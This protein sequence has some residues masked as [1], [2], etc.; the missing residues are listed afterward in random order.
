ML[1]AQKDPIYG[2]NLN[3]KLYIYHC[4]LEEYISKDKN[5][6]KIRIITRRLVNHYTKLQKNTQNVFIF[7]N[8]T[9]DIELIEDLK[10]FWSR[11]LWRIYHKDNKKESKDVIL[12]LISEI[13]KTYL[14][15]YYISNSEKPVYHENEQRFFNTNCIKT[16]LN[17]CKLKMRTEIEKKKNIDWIVKIVNSVVFRIT[18]VS[19]L[20]ILLIIYINKTEDYSKIPANLTVIGLIITI[21]FQFLNKKN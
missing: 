4:I 3:V 5:T 21:I 16:I 17:E 20:G 2:K 9:F 11:D 7:N 1:I 19:L 18:V 8:S 10:N 14:S 6:E 12:L 15:I 13:K